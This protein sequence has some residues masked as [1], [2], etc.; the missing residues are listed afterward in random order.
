MNINFLGNY[1]GEKIISKN[2][3]KY[4]AAMK[5]QINLITALKKK[6]DINIY[7]EMLVPIYPKSKYFIIPS[8]KIL[9]LNENN[10][11]LFRY[12][13]LPFIREIFISLQVLI[14]YLVK[15]LKKNKII[16]I[17]YNLNL[18]FALPLFILEKIGIL[19]FVPIVLDLYPLDRVRKNNIRNIFNE[20]N[21]KLQTFILKNIKKSIVIN[22][23]IINDFRL[24]SS[25]IIEGGVSKKDCFNEILIKNKTNKKIIVFTGGIDSINGIDFLIKTLEK[26]KNKNYELHLY[27]TG[28]LV[29]F[30]KIE[31][32]KNKKIKYMGY[33]KNEEILEI[34]R[35]ADFLI[36]PRKKSFLNL[37]YTFPSKLFEYMLSGTPVICTN[38]PG[39]TEEYKENLFIADTENEIEFAKIIDEVLFISE[40]KLKE[41]SKKAKEFI[42]KNKN[43]DIQ[44]KKIIN[45]L[46]EE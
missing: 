21:F 11:K 37:R 5:W 42:I 23:N 46:S 17:Q 43:W 27:G 6:V 14:I 32:E 22:E 12:I 38:I 36:I 8:L 40:D 10:S 24:K 13:N 16:V 44:A 20:I 41:K 35:A 39:L 1:V 7:S 45:F 4:G 2:I 9:K 25:L 19:S 15:G 31:A 33:K 28:E 18:K 30:V 26:V 34:Q 29:E 3:I